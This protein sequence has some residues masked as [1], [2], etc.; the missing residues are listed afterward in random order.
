[1]EKDKMDREITYKREMSSFFL[2]SWDIFFSLHITHLC[3]Y[4]LLEV[5]I[6]D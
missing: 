6:L 2:D 1:M 4:I 3:K 5:S